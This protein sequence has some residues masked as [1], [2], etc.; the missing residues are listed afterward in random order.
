VY[1][2]VRLSV[3]VLSKMLTM[4]TWLICSQCSAAMHYLFVCFFVPLRILIVL[5]RLLY[6]SRSRAGKTCVGIHNT[7]YKL[8]RWVRLVFLSFSLYRYYYFIKISVWSVKFSF[9]L[10]N[11]NVQVEVMNEREH[12]NACVRRTHEHS[13]MNG[14]DF[15]LG[16]I[17]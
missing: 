9:L 10:F 13:T 11:I 8:I 12:T 15:L 16:F 1:L 14:C 4:T 6:S 17:F 5:S 3:C 2:C 7:I